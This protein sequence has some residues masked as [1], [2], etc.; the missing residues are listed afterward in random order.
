V[1]E[2]EKATD[3]IVTVLQGRME[4]LPERVL[5]VQQQV[6]LELLALKLLLE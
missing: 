6:R 4:I 3:F 5:Y 1:R 2:P